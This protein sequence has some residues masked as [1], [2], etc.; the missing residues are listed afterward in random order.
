MTHEYEGGLG[1]ELEAMLYRIDERQAE[2]A[3]RGIR[4]WLLAPTIDIY[5]ALM[6]GETVPPEQLNQDA[7]HRYGSKKRGVA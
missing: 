6:R 4:A 7:L 1:P 3:R 2:E 5:I